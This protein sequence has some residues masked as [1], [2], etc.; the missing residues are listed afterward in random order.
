MIERKDLR[1]FAWAE[2][3]MVYHVM[4]VPYDPTRHAPSKGVS[5]DPRHQISLWLP[6]MVYPMAMAPS[7]YLK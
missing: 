5:Y 4:G 6:R 7:H 3:A 1:T 2:G